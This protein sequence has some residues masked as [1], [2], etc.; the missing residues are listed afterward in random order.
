MLLMIFVIWA[1][2]WESH[3]NDRNSIHVVVSVNCSWILRV[4]CK[5]NLSHMNDDFRNKSQLFSMIQVI[6]RCTAYSY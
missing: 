6:F 3:D 2:G 4:M 1:G 5:M